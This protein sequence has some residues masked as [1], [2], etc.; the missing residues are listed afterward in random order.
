MAVIMPGDALVM[1]GYG[2][3][4]NLMD[5]LRFNKHCNYCRLVVQF[6]PREGWSG[7][8]YDK[9]LKSQFEVVSTNLQV[10]LDGLMDEERKYR[11]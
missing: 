7:R 5:P 11:K 1:K 2:F 10:V 4:Q 3:H 9:S 6:N 8:L